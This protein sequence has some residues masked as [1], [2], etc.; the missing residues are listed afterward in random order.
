M[1][2]RRNAFPLG[3]TATVTHLNPSWDLQTVRL[4]RVH[5]VS[6]KEGGRGS[7]QLG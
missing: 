5:L 7:G 2:L 3:G 1:V 6:A 4:S